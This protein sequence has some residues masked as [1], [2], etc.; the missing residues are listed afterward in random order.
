MD[1]VCHTLLGAAIGKAGLER[2]SPRANV[3]LM[4]ASNLPDLDALVFLT[5]TPSVSF[6]RGWTHGALAQLVLPIALA[7]AML[8][9]DRLQTRRRGQRPTARPAAVLGLCYIGLLSHVFLDFLNNYG[10]RLLM[11]FSNRWFYGDAVFIVD[12]WLWLA[13]GAGVFLARRWRVP[14][15]ARIALALTSIYIAGMLWLAAESRRIV[16]DSWTMARGSAPAGLMVGPTPV[17]PF[18]KQVIVDAGDHYETGELRWWPRAVRFDPR[19]VPK[20]EDLPPVAR[21][22]QD[23]RVRA[24]LVWARFPYYDVRAA[25]DRMLVTLRD[26]RFGDR[27][28][29]VSVEVPRP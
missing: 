24:V 18:R 20:N 15:P 16:L 2:W 8:A 23:E 10:I 17:D 12:P 27:V 19:V 9:V 5:G 13:L 28:G 4:I 6:R 21:A 25:G 26:M 22:R 14:G 1:N 29:G 3:T 7:A 11:P